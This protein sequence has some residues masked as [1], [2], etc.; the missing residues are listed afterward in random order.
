MTL[1]TL[2]ALLATIKDIA[3]WIAIIL[4]IAAFTVS[5]LNYRRDRANLRVTSTYF[6]GGPQS[7]AGI[8]IDVV[9]KGRRPII[10]ESLVYVKLGRNKLGGQTVVE[11]F[12]AHLNSDGG[13]A[14]TERQKHRK[15]L[16]A[17][18]LGVC[19]ENDD[20]L[21]AD[22]FRITDTLHH[23]Y[24]IKGIRKQIAQLRAWAEKHPGPVSE[25]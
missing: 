9:N 1:D 5:V 21:E 14:L 16:S 12:G 2:L 4:S 24:R 19:F 18:E 23:R 25:W 3:P 17:P 15:W 10:L 6:E 11:S 22:E 8:S 20:V 13:I 7:D